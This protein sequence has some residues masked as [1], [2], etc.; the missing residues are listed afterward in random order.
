MVELDRIIGRAVVIAGMIGLGYWARGKINNV[1]YHVPPIYNPHPLAADLF[2]AQI[3]LLNVDGAQMPVLATQSHK[4]FMER[5]G[6]DVVL[7]PFG[8]QRQPM[9]RDTLQQ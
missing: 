8:Y 3:Y 2:E 7:R 1:A 6:D 4:Y 9:P 5:S